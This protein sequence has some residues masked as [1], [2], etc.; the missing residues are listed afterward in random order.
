MYSFTKHF[1]RRETEQ[2]CTR[3]IFGIIFF[4]QLYVDLQLSEFKRKMKICL[5]ELGVKEKGKNKRSLIFFSIKERAR[6]KL[7][8]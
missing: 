6:K 5:L 4:L 2:S 3:D 8:Y 7:F 1:H